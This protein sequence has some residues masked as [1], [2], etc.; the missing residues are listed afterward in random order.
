MRLALI[1]L[2]QEWV[3]YAKELGYDSHCIKVQDYI[4]REDT[5]NVYYISPSNCL[6]FMDSGVDHTYSR[7]MF[8]GIETKI[9][10]R[11]KSIGFKTKLGRYYLPIGK[12]I[13]TPTDEYTPNGN[14]KCFMI[15][16]PTM[17]LP[18]DVS[19][20]P[21]AYLCMMSVI[22]LLKKKKEEFGITDQDELVITSFCCGYGKMDTRLSMDQINKAINQDDPEKVKL[23]YNDILTLQP[24]Y[25]ENTEWTDIHPNS[26]IKT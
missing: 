13:C 1:S 12:A 17:L 2:D 26:I 14:G 25:Y 24:K 4:P 5:K 10:K 16:S 9:K 21:N 19:N 6:N 22:Q 18:Q 23:N 15:S 8:S 20:T 3:K 7:I 11:I